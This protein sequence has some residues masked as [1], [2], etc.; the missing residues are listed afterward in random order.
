MHTLLYTL[1]H[2]PRKADG[3]THNQKILACYGTRRFISVFTRWITPLSYTV[4]PQDVFTPTSRPE[5]HK[6]QAPGRRGD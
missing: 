5:M 2:N 3:W 1:E 6:S 4:M